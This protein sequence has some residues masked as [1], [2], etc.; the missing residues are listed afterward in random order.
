MNHDE[1]L[2]MLRRAG[3]EVPGDD[4]PVEVEAEVEDGPSVGSSTSGT[5]S[6]SAGPQSARARKKAAQAARR[7]AKAAS[8]SNRARVERPVPPF[9]ERL[10]Q[11]S[12][13]ALIVA[14]VVLV[15]AA[16]GCYWW[17]HPALNLQSPQVWSWIIMASIV[18][19]V[20]LKIAALRTRKH[21][22]LYNRLALVPL[23]VIV[24]FFIG[25]LLGEPFMPGNAERYATVL[26][27]TEG[28]FAKDIQEVDYDEVPVIDRASAQ[29][30]GSRAMGSIPEFVSQ[31]EISDAYSQINY[32]G[33]PVRVSPLTYADLFKWLSNRDTGIPAY[34]LVDM[35]TQEAEVVRLEEPI[36]Y[37]ESEPLAR[38]IDR[39]VQLKYPT[40]M[41]D[42]KS[43]E[44]DEEGTPWW[45][46]PVQRRTIGLFE[47]T[48][49]QRVVL[50]NA[51]TG[52]TEDYAIEDCPTWVDR[53]YPS[54]L[55]IQQYN[56]SGAYK[57]G[58]LNSWLGQQGVVHTTQGTDGELG[59]NYLAQD[60][61]IY[62]YTGVS[63]VTA[64]SSNVGFILVNQRTGESHYYPVAGATEDS[65]QASAE[66]QVQ[67]LR[68]EAT[69]PLLLNVAD[70][71][72]YFMA[73]KDSAGLVKMY[74]MINV[75]HYQS[76]AT[77]S[78]VAACQENYLQMLASAGALSEEEAAASGA[79]VEVTGTIASM[80]QA[81]IDGNS[82]FYLTLE[83]DGAIYDVALPGLVGIVR[84]G[85][86]S[87]ITLSYAKESAG[88]VP[89]AEASADDEAGAQATDEPR[90]VTAIG[91][92]R[93]VV[94]AEDD[95]AAAGEDAV[96]AD[97]GASDGDDAAAE[98]DV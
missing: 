78:T 35:V 57:N 16:A 63:S 67:N 66:G 46:F 54:D 18:A 20:G 40:Y 72:T 28:D 11:W 21:D 27:T 60:G 85:V 3:V 58:W 55:I 12:R 82:H 76:V 74:A 94:A 36:R 14:L 96:V 47:G 77:G 23:A 68:Y 80:A 8:K 65:A 83:G 9:M 88:D 62:L 91:G 79:E 31:F 52:E 41:F 6:A 22:V 64:D 86:G 37:S 48:T 92:K 4:G 2:D 10:A 70:Q 61:D 89:D 56:W 33:R 95:D 98:A 49:I 81:V 26:D 5:S 1:L 7:R 87:E 93:A 97:A 13:R 51:C 90:R 44:L 30:L 24:A 19:L 15:V 73:L 38:N 42:Q 25:L 34:V 50:V 71:P 43:F 29:L 45:V 39:Y 75:E 17:F 59:Y 53:A 32:Q 69:Y 84:Y